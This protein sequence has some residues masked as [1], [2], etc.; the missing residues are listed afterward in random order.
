[1]QLYQITVNGIPFSDPVNV[2]MKNAI[3]QS[4]DGVVDNVKCE[5]VQD[6]PQPRLWI[7]EGGRK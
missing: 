1:M 3:L 6:K 2:T 7:V 4:L 5:E